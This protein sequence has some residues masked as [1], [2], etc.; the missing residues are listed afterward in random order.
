MRSWLELGHVSILCNVLRVVNRY[1]RFVA[2][3]GAL[4]SRLGDDMAGTALLLFA[5][6][7]SSQGDG[8]VIFGLLTVAAAV[9][10]PLLGVWMDR[11]RSALPLASSLALFASGLAAVG[12][13]MHA[14]Q[15]EVAM[16]FAVATGL[17]GPAVAGGWSA[18]LR[19]EEPDRTHKLMIFDASS[20]SVAGL[21]GPAL[22]G[23]A[24]GAGG[25]SVPMVVTVVL[26]AGG[27]VCACFAPPRSGRSHIAVDRADAT[28]CSRPSPISDLRDGIAAIVHQTRLRR[29]TVSSC[30]AFFGFGSFAV[31]G[32]SIGEA[33]FGTP[34]AG[35]LILSLLAAAALT[36]NVV[37]GRLYVLERPARVLTVA[38]AVVGV[39]MT[40]LLVDHPAATL[41]AAVLIG[42][43]DGPQLASLISIRHAEA[44]ARLRTQIFTTSA[45][46]KVTAS[47]FGAL[48]AAPL[49]HDGIAPAIVLAAAAYVVSTAVAARVGDAARGEEGAPV[50]RR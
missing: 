39:G 11:A 4:L 35:S 25:P 31:L 36:A 34:A 30:V 46:L 19:A 20:Y 24:Y 45:S 8:A 12:V 18:F 49:V 37:L 48:T 28:R 22:A 33:R 27:S 47:G 10:G 5:F 23:A 40:T 17:F 1:R 2:P 13:S 6:A 38:T 41:A 26:L 43:G 14:H 44:P 29:A 7:G 15:D 21:L 9:G 50:P 32:P 3:S 16:V 42:A